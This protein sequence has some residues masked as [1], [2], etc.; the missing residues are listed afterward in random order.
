VWSV[1]PTGF[2]DRKKRIENFFIINKKGQR[3]MAASV[4]H[5]FFSSLQVLT[6]A[7]CNGVPR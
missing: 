5:I 3:L 6:G 2:A 7:Q 4:Y 1:E